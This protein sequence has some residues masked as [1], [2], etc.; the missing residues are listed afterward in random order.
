[1]HPKNSNARNSRSINDLINTRE[2]KRICWTSLIKICVIH[3]HVPGAI[4]L[5]H[6]HLVS[7][8]L[9]IKNFHGKPSCQEPG[10]FLSDGLPSLLIKTAKKLFDR[11]KLWINIKSVL[12]EFPW[13]TRHV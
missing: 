11:L 6:Q 7:Q 12:N 3:T 13:Y 4:F 9:R 8:P 10:Y 2:G 5:K 1:M